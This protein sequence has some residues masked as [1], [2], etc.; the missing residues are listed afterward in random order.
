MYLSCL[1]WNLERRLYK[2]ERAYLCFKGLLI[3]ELYHKFNF[4]HHLL[5]LSQFLELTQ[6]EMK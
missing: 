4:Y 1:A 2:D 5:A 6:Q 3:T